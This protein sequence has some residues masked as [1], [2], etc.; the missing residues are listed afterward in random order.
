MNYILHILVNSIT[1]GIVAIGLNLVVGVTGLA[2]FGHAA[3]AGVAAYTTALLSNYVGLSPWLGLALGILI[4]GSIGIL[5]G[6]V[7]LRLRGDYLALATFALG[8]LA[9]CVARNWVSVTRGPLG[10][11][12]IPSLSVANHDLIS[13]LE[14]LPVPVLCLAAVLAVTACIMR[15]PLGR[16]LRAIRE[17][18]TAAMTCGKDTY[19]AKVKIFGVGAGIAGI[20][21]S[22]NAHYVRFVSPDSF[23]IT[24]TI[25]VLLMVIL[26]GLGSFWGPLVGALLLTLVPELLRFVGLPTGSAPY[27]RQILYGLILITLMLWRPQGLL[28][29]HKL[30]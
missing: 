30:R 15:S 26:G 8:L 12:G 20:A 24:E 21:G 10:L 5:V 17:D 1:Y 22:L 2:S 25:L 27:A 6:A 14:F 28:G 19:G 7:A 18:E 11:P 16:V 13:P 3:F 9:A 29:T 4:A 23:S